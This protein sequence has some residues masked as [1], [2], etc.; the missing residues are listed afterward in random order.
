[1]Y[2]SPKL[3][4]KDQAERKKILKSN[5]WVT[6]KPETEWHCQSGASSLEAPLCQ[7]DAKEQKIGKEYPVEKRKKII[8]KL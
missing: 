1:M 5:V 3:G 8:D 7:K 4:R 2:V 6:L